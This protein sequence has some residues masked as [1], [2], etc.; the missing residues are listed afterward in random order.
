MNKRIKKKHRRMKS[1]RRLGDGTYKEKYIKGNPKIPAGQVFLIK[2]LSYAIC[3][4]EIDVPTI[5]FEL[6]NSYTFTKNL[7]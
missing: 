4:I 5:S 1:V 7:Y 3:D 6:S 2:P